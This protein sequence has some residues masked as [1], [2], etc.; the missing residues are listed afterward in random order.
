MSDNITIH[1]ISKSRTII[2]VVVHDEIWYRAKDVAMPLGYKNTKQS[3]IDH[4]LIDNTRRLNELEPQ[5]NQ[6]YNDANTIY[7][8][9]AGFRSLVINSFITDLFQT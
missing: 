9:E 8:N 6:Y 2:C 4:V 3:V 7:I 1:T 5:A